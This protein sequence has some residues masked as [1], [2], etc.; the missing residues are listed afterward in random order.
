[1]PGEHSVTGSWSSSLVIK[2]PGQEEVL[3][4]LGAEVHDGG[5]DR[6]NGQHGHRGTRTHGLVEEDELLD[7]RSTLPAV[8]L[9]PADAQPAVLGHLLHH[10]A[11]VGADAVAVGQ[12]LFD[13]RSKESRVVVP[14]LPTKALLLF[15]VADLHGVPPWWPAWVRR[16]CGSRFVPAVGPA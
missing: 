8:L 9:G 13:L 4:R 16:S 3:L 12:L 6:I 11:H 14:E 7:G 5:A 10:P 1:V 15:G 2:V